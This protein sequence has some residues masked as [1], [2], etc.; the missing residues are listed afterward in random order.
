MREAGFTQFNDQA[1]ELVAQGVRW[2]WRGQAFPDPSAFP[3]QTFSKDLEPEFIA[4]SAVSHASSL[5]PR[6]LLPFH[7][8]QCIALALHCIGAM[9]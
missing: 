7:A 3:E 9:R 1:E 8:C 5:G 2:V 6:L 4:L